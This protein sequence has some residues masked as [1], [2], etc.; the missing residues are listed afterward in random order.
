MS[1]K[2]APYVVHIDD[3]EEVEGAYG[4]PF[5]REKLSIYRELGRAAGS[6]TLGFSFERL[7]PGRRTSFTHA[8]SAEEEFIYLLSGTCHVRIVEDGS[9]A[10]EIPL[11]AGHAVSFPAGTAI[12]HTFVNRGSDECTLLVVGERRPGIDRVF[13]P[14]DPD[15]DTYHAEK[16]P[17]QHWTLPSVAERNTTP[18]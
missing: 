14:E 6:K 12:A 2:A 8:H 15:Y 11:R 17:E 7:P 16:R 13:Y 10:R 3:V 1:E 9:E 18:R 4:A 5:D